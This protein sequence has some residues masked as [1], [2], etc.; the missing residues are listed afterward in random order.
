MNT[1]WQEKC[2][3]NNRLYNRS[4]FRFAGVSCNQNQVILKIGLTSY[5]HLIGTNCHQVFG[6]QLVDLGVKH[7]SSRSVYLANPLG[8]GSLL[9]TKDNKVLFLKRAMWTG[10][11]KGKIDRPGGKFFNIYS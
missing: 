2:L 10:E 11:E 9:I 1:I 6:S 7:Y 3:E 8:V 4:K 5:K